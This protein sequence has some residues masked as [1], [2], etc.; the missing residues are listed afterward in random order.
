MKAQELLRIIDALQHEIHPFTGELYTDPSCVLKEKLVKQAF[1]SIRQTIMHTTKIERTQL[2]TEAV[3][4]LCKKLR[5]LGYEPTAPQLVKIYLG[6]RTVIDADLRSLPAYGSYKGFYTRKGLLALV[7]S[8]ARRHPEELQEN[9]Q[10]SIKSRQQPWQK[11]PFF[12]E[13]SFNNLSNQDFES[14]T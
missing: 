11:E 8:V 10:L 14:L 9:N 7:Q 5:S 1:T 13:K 3:L 4:K 2:D 6:S 12:E